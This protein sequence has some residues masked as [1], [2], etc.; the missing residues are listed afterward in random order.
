VTA[1]SR[2]A[3]LIVDIQRDFCEGGSLAVAGGTAVA[4]AITAYARA[5]LDAY[6][7][8]VASRDWHRPE[9]SNDGHIAVPPDVA[10]YA[11]SW[12]AHC[13]A[14]TSGA[15][16]APGFDPSL[17]AVTVLKGYGYPAYSMFQGSDTGARG[18]AVDGWPTLDARLRHDGVGEVDVVGIAADYCCL[19][20]A[21]DA[22]AAGFGVRVL[23][24][25]QVGVGADSTSAAWAELTD[26]G[27]TVTTTARIG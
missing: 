5:H 8:I 17:A 23:Q 20:T 14:G 7:V 3:L 11:E 10:D 2:R 15:E 25:L 16:F 9:E 27:A 21:R 22:L 6:E 19:A 4:T 26:A 24:D 12:P 18:G 1:P 13:L